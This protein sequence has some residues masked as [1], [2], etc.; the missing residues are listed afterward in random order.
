[1]EQPFEC[2]YCGSKFHREKTLSTHMC[3]KKKRHMEIE[4]AGSRFGFRTFQKFYEL[5]AR[6]KKPKTQQEF[7][8]SPYYTDFAKFGNH[9]SNL[10]PIYVDQYIEFVILGG[11]KLKDW[12]KDDIYY[13]FVVDMLKKEPPTSAAERTITEIMQWAEK[14]GTP[15]TQFF[16]DVTANE[17]AHLIKTGRISPWVLYLCD[18]G[19]KLMSRFS[20]D[21]SKMIGDVIDPGSWMKTFKKSPEDVEYI[22]SI[23]EQAGL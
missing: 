23:L 9:L 19:E 2:K 11:V 13:L 18:S 16:T 12:T 3:V 21:H 8:D 7:I 20:E 22:K 5:T 14:N 10:K 1:M 4:T 17:A 15:F 6:A